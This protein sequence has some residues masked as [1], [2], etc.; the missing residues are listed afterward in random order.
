MRATITTIVLVFT[1]SVVSRVEARAWRGII[2]LQTTRAA[3]VQILGEGTDSESAGTKYNFENENVSILYSSAD[4]ALPECARKLPADLVLAIKV[5][6]KVEVSLETLGLMRDS[7]KTLPTLSDSL[8]TTAFVDDDEGLVMS[9]S[10]GTQQIAYLP[11]KAE[12]ARCP[13]FYGDL[14]T[15]VIR[16]IICI[17]CPT[18]AVDCPED[19]EAG[20]K[21]TFTAHVTV[22]TPAPELAFN[23]T[24]DQGTIVG[25][26][27]TAVIKVDT[28]NLGDKTITATVEVNGIDPS[29]PRTASC[30][31]PIVKRRKGSQH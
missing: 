2:P 5:F 7:V 24:V 18:V 26:Q 28:T 11:S 1:L 22:G 12:R 17:L 21:I 30:S 31:T 19:T 15:F 29:C 8:P 3:V 9:A 13:D 6:P 16:R 20:S 25:G 4:T 27:G 14:S 23:W 10:G